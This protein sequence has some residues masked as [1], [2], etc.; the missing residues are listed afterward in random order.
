VGGLRSLD[1]IES[2][3]DAGEADYFSLCRPLIR[4]PELPLRW[5]RGDRR[6]ADC[7]SCLGCFGPTRRGEGLRCVKTEPEG[8][9]A[10]TA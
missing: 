2:I 3:L 8:P 10:V 7:V 5:N 4:E 6:R 9:P 1:V